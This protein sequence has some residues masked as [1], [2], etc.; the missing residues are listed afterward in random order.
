MT[1]GFRNP[2]DFGSGL[3][4][5]IFGSVFVAI[6]QNYPMGAVEKM[7]P[8]FFPTVLGAL[9][10][11]N[12]AAL[13]IRSFLQKGTGLP[14]ASW[15]GILLTM[16][17]ITC[18]GLL[19]K[20]A[21]LLISVMALVIVSACASSQFRLWSSLLLA[22]GLSIFSGLVFAQALGLPLPLLGSWFPN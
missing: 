18:F 9:L 22:V 16:A 7:G 2:K 8:G 5:F 13:V 1:V 21:G 6:G 14:G 15:R 10:A 17:A 3:I 12:G 11:L 19:L 4:F 20:T